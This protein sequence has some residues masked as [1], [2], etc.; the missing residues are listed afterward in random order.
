[1]KW[2]PSR[3][4]CISGPTSSVSLR[5]FITEESQEGLTQTL[6]LL[7]NFANLFPQIK[8]NQSIK[9]KQ[10]QNQPKQNKTTN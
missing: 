10:T 8:I 3:V 2:K 5:P 6:L 9:N 4:P 7:S 1:M